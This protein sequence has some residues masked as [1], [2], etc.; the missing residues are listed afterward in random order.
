MIVCSGFSSSSSSFS[1]LEQLVQQ[2]RAPSRPRASR[3]PARSGTR[4]SPRGAR[5]RAAARAAVRPA[6]RSRGRRRGSRGPTF[7]C[8]ATGR[9]GFSRPVGLGELDQ[10][11]AVQHA[12][13][14]VQVPGVD[15]EAGGELAVR[16]RA[17]GLAE[18][19]QHLQPQRVAERLQLLGAVDL[20]DIA[21]LRL[22]LGSAH[23]SSVTAAASS[24]KTST[25]TG[26]RRTRLAGHLSGDLAGEGA[27]DGVG[28]VGAGDEEDD[29]G[30]AVGSSARSS[31][32]GRPTARG[33]PGRRRRGGLGRRAAA[34]RGRARPCVRRGRARAASGR[35]G[36]RRAPGR[37]RPR[38]R[39]AGAR[40]GC[41]GSRAAAAASWSSRFSFARRKFER[42]SSG[43]TQRS[44]PHQTVARAP[45]RLE[46]RCFAVGIGRRW[47]RP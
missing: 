44:S 19:L 46:R 18:H 12:H 47:S 7:R 22:R 39:R 43:G 36:R 28:L 29:P 9:Y 8:F 24:R 3:A 16:Q 34:S 42:S 10:A 6:A 45:V 2:R 14:E 13:V 32:R 38:R 4:R 37:A 21:R 5:S 27:R 25:G 41:G 23:G 11:G 20:E 26:A 1:S 17:V 35:T 33:Q 30:G 31:S 40:R 15:R